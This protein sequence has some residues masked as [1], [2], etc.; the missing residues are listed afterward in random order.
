MTEAIKNDAG[1]PQLSLLPYGLI[2]AMLVCPDEDNI[3]SA[4]RNLAYSTTAM[5]NKDTMRARIF[6]DIAM[7]SV[8][9]TFTDNYAAL[10]T[11][12]AAF[13]YGCKK[14]SRN[15]WREGFKWSRL[16]DAA[17]RHLTQYTV[18]PIDEE[19]GNDHRGHALAMLGMLYEHV[20]NNLG[21]NDL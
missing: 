17:L 12:A 13:E 21:E 1:K 5:R 8:R 11:A 14:Y 2:N 19:S 20:E 9:E 3:A 18:N 10:T 7:K 16:M 6:L 4:V 15:N